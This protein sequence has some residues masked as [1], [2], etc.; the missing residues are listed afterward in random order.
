M[1]ARQTP[2]AGTRIHAEIV[3]VNLFAV[4]SIDAK[5]RAPIPATS[6]SANAAVRSLKENGG[7]PFTVRS[8][9]VP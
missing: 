3:V 1:P 6:P 7:V 2:D 8:G 4:R 9:A 5:T